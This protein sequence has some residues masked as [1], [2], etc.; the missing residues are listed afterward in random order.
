MHRSDHDD[1]ATQSAVSLDDQAL[2]SFKNA[3][4]TAIDYGSLDVVR[5]LLEYGVDPN[6]GGHVWPASR[7]GSPTHTDP[8]N[9]VLEGSHY[10]INENVGYDLQTISKHHTCIGRCKCLS[11]ISSQVTVRLRG[12]NTIRYLLIFL[13]FLTSV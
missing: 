9:I 3:L 6:S 5:T 4:H 7:P 11:S 1:L 13:I 8:C 10:K 12:L 2:L